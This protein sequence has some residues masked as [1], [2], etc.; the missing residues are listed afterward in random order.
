VSLR[1]VRR[2]ETVPTNAAAAAA[3][4]R[5]AVAQAARGGRSGW[6][7]GRPPLRALQVSRGGSWGFHRLLLR[8]VFGLGF[9]AR[10]WAL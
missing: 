4:A 1:G 10:S 5:V 3:A 2:R 6:Q 8:R 9:G 7:A